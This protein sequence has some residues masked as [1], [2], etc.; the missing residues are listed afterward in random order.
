[1]SKVYIVEAKRSAIG[2]F[3]GA[4]SGITAGELAGQVMKKTLDDLGIDKSKIDEVVLGNVLPAGQGQGIARQASIYAGVPAEVP[5]YTINIICGSGMKTVMS[6]YNAI[7]AAEA[8]LIVAGGVEVM[9]QVPFVTDAKVRTGYKMGGMNLKDGII[10]DG[11]TDVFNNYHMGITAE[12]IADKYKIDRIRQDEFAM[13]SQEKAIKAID[14][15]RFKDEII[16]VE[17]KTRKENIIFDKDEYPNRATTLEALNRLRPAFKS[18]GTVTAGN[19][20]GINDGASI[21]IV[22][23]E[24]AVK[25]YNLKPIV[26][27]VSVGQSGVDPSIMGLGPVPAIKN[28]LSKCELSLKDINLIELNEAF[29]V[30]S[31]GVIEELKAE[32]EGVDDVWF[33][34]RTNVNGGAIALGHPLGASGARITTTLIHEMKKQNVEYGLAS[35]CIGGGMGTCI[36]LK[37]V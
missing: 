25:E 23:S 15:D 18:D 37:L 34:E 22:A 10:I 12:N 8:N 5:A 26:E 17:I 6:A 24:K 33:A 1:M 20:S 13:K 21:I 29:A 31:L 2:K 19:A 16:P 32:H 11:L 14:S 9:S 4:L 36:I 27:I 35:L 7:K 30:Q 28:A 3:G